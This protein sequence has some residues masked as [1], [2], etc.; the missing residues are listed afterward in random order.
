[1]KC[2]LFYAHSKQAFS[3]C[4][5]PSPG[6]TK[7]AIWEPSSTSSPGSAE[8]LGGWVSGPLATFAISN[9]KQGI[10]MREIKK[11]ELAPDS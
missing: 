9:G 5:F 11:A 6:E 4:K 8:E 10:S 7:P 1:M 3:T 2:F